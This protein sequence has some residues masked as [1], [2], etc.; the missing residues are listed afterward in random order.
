M[1]RLHALIFTLLIFGCSG[2]PPHK[3]S[4][5]KPVP[6]EA[7]PVQA[8]T[9]PEVTAIPNPVRGKKVA[10]RILAEGNTGVRI[11]IYDHFLVEIKTLEQEG[12]GLYDVLW[13]FRRLEEG[14]YYFQANVEDKIHGH[15]FKLKIQKLVVLKD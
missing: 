3:P 8:L 10:F 9:E 2:I 15:L 4:A 7:A 6:T 5:E 11:K 13:E 12:N 1:N 14:I